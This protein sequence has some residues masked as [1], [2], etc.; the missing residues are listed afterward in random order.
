MADWAKFKFFY[1][2]MLG[3]AGST[4]TA[5]STEATGDHDVD[6]IHNWLETNMWE[7]EDIGLADPQY[8]TLDLGASNTADCDYLCILGHN[9]NTVG[10]TVTLQ[11]STDDF[12]ADIN[13][14]FTGVAPSADTVFLKE[15]TAP[16]AKRYWRLK[17]SGHGSTAPYMAI[18]VWGLTTELDYATASFDPYEQ[19]VKAAVG[20]SQGGYVT[21]VHT[22]YAER[23]LNL[24]F[25]DADS[26]L[27]GKVKSWH[28]SH[29]LKNLFVAWETANNPTDVYLM[30]PSAKFRNPFNQTGLYRN[31]SVQLTGRT[32]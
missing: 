21:G 32:E 22:Q 16:G 15:F 3:A 18:C 29:G 1:D 8:L 28:D 17:I 9:L 7:A 4:L 13:D 12:A 23:A 20:I 27:Y 26:T 6:Y 2:T 31:I 5:T 25:A 24:S 30:R 11:Y 19:N 14:A 10:A